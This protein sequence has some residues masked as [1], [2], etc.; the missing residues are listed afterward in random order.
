MP[1]CRLIYLT[2][3]RQVVRLNAKPIL[4]LLLIQ[5]ITST[6]HNVVTIVELRQSMNKSDEPCRK[7]HVVN[8]HNVL[9][10]I[11]HK[12]VLI[13]NEKYII[14]RNDRVDIYTM[15]IFET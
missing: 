3:S 7:I 15:D 14:G 13:G 1:D 4:C 6:Y 2:I 8:K 12:F 10:G 5:G 9:N 11:F